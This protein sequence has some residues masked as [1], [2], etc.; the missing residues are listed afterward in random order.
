MATTPAFH[1]T[2]DRYH[3][4][5]DPGD[6]A[7]RDASRPA[8]SSSSTC[9]TPAA[10]SST[11]G[12]T[13]D[14]LARLDFDAGR[15]GQRADRGRG[16]RAGRHAPG[17]PARVP[18]R[19]T[20]AG[21]RASRASA[22]WPTTSRS[23][24][25]GSR[26]SPSVGGRAEFLPGIR[27]PVVPFC[28]EIGVAPVDGPRSTIPPDV[29]GGNM[30]TRHLTAG[31]T[32]FLPVFHAGARCRSATA[33]RPR[34]TARSAGPRSRRRCA[35]LVRLT[36][37]KDLH[38][39]RA[40]VPD[41]AG[42]RGRASGRP[43]LRDRRG[44]A[45]PARRGPRRGP[46]DDRLARPRARD[47]ARSTPTCCAAS[48]STCGS[49]RSWTCRTSSSRPTARCRSSTERGDGRASA[50]AGLTGRLSPRRRPRRA[51]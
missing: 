27:V 50:T 14:D 40:R 46:P 3:L 18:S 32:L 51:R 28:G 6:R 47:R 10:A 33:T 39:T 31:A 21:R 44:R 48:R 45:R 15:P 42:R 30:D 2:R 8:A 49:A 13:V 34:A 5:W 41:R 25:C 11:A 24:S 43:P 4:A 29:H 26:G 35:R 7:D 36:V 37:R 19:P 17:R 38:V 23:R 12:S 16:R 9:S 22:C 20:G 1:V